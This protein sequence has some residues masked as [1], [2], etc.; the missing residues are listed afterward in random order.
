MKI[1]IIPVS[2]LV[3]EFILRFFILRMLGSSLFSSSLL[4]FLILL[5]PGGGGGVLTGQG[6]DAISISFKTVLIQATSFMFYCE[7]TTVQWLI[8]FV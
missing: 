1:A 8:S 6:P 4:L 5:G 2:A 3:R 7:A